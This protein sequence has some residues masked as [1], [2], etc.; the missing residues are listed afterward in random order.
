MRHLLAFLAVFATFMV[1]LEAS[2][3]TMVP[4]PAP[5]TGWWNTAPAPGEKF[6]TADAACRRQKEIFNPQAEYDGTSR[7]DFD[8]N[9]CY[10]HRPPWMNPGILPGIVWFTCPNGTTQTEMRQCVT[11]KEVPECPTCSKSRP[12]SEGGPPEVGDPISLATGSQTETVTDYSTADGLLAVVRH[13]RSIQRGRANAADHELPGF[14]W[15]WH[16]IV[17]GRIVISGSNEESAEYHDEHGGI[18]FLTASTSNLNS[19]DYAPQGISHIK[20]SSVG[21]PSVDRVDFFKNGASVTNGSAEMRVDFGGGEYILFRRSDVYRFKPEIRFLVPIEHGFPGG[22]K[23]YF[24]Y[25][26]TGEYP[27]KIRDSFGR[28]ILIDWVNASDHIKVISQLHLPDGTSLHYDYDRATFAMFT[29]GGFAAGGSAGGAI[30]ATPSYYEDFPEDRLISARHANAS[31]VTLWSRDYLYEAPLYPYG[32]TGFKN[33]AGERLATISYS[34]SGRTL[35]AERAGGFDKYTVQYLQDDVTVP[36]NFVRNVTGPLGRQQTYKFF[37]DSGAAASMRMVL[38]EIDTAASSTVPASTQTFSYTDTNGYN[39]M[40]SG[41]QDPRGNVS[42]LTVDTAKQRP[43]AITEAQGT[44]VARTTDITWHSQFDLPTH[45]ERQG[46]D[47]DYTYDASGQVL[48]RTETDT[49]THT[50]PYSTNGQTRTTSYTWNSDGRLLTVN[51]P[52]PPDSSSNDDIVTF[53]YD[54][55]GNQLSMTDGLG[56]VTQYGSHDANGRP[57]TMTDMNGVV[58]EFTYNGRGRVLTMNVKHPSNSSLDALTTMEYDEEGRVTGITRPATDKIIFDYNLAGLLTSMRAASGER[59][60]Y[61]HDAMGNVTKETVK[62]TNGTASRTTVRTF[63]SLGRM[64]SETLGPRRVTRW[65]YDA[66]G[67][68]TTL[69]NP[70]NNATTQAF[71]ALDRLITTVAPDGGTTSLVHDE[72]DGVV[73]NSDPK[74]VVT[75]FVRNGFG[76]VIQEVSPDR[77]TSTYWYDAAGS[78]TKSQDGRGQIVDYS[79]DILGRLSQKVPQ[80]LTGETVS[81]SWDTGGLSGSYGVGRLGAITDASGTTQFKYDNRGNMLVQQQAIGS[82]ATAQL[83]YA[84]DLGDRITQL[85]YPSGRIMQYGRDSKGRV[86]T[87][88]TKA[89]SS[90]GSWT[91][92]ADTFTYEPFAAVKSFALGNGLSVANDWGNDGR[93]ASRRLY[94]TSGGMNLSW[95]SYAYDANDNVTAIAD[96]L[97]DA[98]SIFYGYDKNDRLVQTALTVGSPTSAS[99]TY[100]YTTGT[101]RLASIGNGAGTRSIGY[102]GRGNTATESRPGSISASASYDGYGRLTGYSRTD[103]GTFSFLYNGRDDRVSMTNGV[104]TRRF[105]YDPD[106]RVL[107]EYGVSAADVKAEFIWAL[108]QV[109]NDETFGGD[110]GAGGYMPLVVATP[111]SGGMIVLNWMH[112]NHLGVPLI[113]TNALGSAATTPN[114]YQAPGF[115]GQ[116]RIVADLYYNRYRD[117]DPTTGRYIQAD[118]IGLDGGQNSYVYAENNPTVYVDPLGL[119]VRPLPS[120]RGPLRPFPEGEARREEGLRPVRLPPPGGWRPQPRYR[121]GETFIGP[122]G[123]TPTPRQIAESRGQCPPF[124]GAFSWIHP[125]RYTSNRDLRR[126]WEKATGN[127]W[128]KDPKTGRNQDV[129]HEIPLANGGPDALGNVRPRARDEHIQ[130]HRDANDYSNWAKRRGN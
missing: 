74:S 99:D 106:G 60:D 84:Y 107:G 50:A 110:D 18:E 58:T 126:Q 41:V 44:G 80:G 103:V 32:L 79:Y 76:D 16:G 109:A 35:S 91:G 31:N 125:G 112:G 128:P 82:S 28:E 121:P 97:D 127:P 46:L 85:T 92:I 71:D 10:W 22:Y 100:S 24:D 40:L 57:G 30:V 12:P 5:V 47:I 19:Y 101:N 11:G 102:D 77:G 67:N 61:E 119:Q 20:L 123:S 33:S 118:P 37:R 96:N 95:L 48:S 43:T 27:S 56:H 117:F 86:S 93:L 17:P 55:D 83:V 8:D 78:M 1:S 42:A 105:I 73:E 51:G 70:L 124:E 108:P 130:R 69:T 3:Q 129:S 14:G 111:D 4:P 38:S 122:P 26:D 98:N 53:A 39:F 36:E 75:T 49:T 88:Q 72:K 62:R 63:D 13:Y 65:A 66:N 9:N 68:A 2:A 120:P 116:S 89:S 90:V 34:I 45:E 23:Q 87:V 25:P 21:T 113:A 64:L 114:D 6:A 54:T 81:Y 15:A 104:G 59:I 7:A 94:Q 52:R 29:A 115:P